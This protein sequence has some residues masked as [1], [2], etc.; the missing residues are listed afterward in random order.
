MDARDIGA[1]NKG[2]GKGHSPIIVKFSSSSAQCAVCS[3]L[4]VVM[5]LNI[6]C[7]ESINF[8]AADK[9]M[10]CRTVLTDA[11]VGGSMACTALVFWHSAH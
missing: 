5:S 9:K 7:T 3:T 1:I 8:A 6:N 10:I 4:Y 2:K 11:Q